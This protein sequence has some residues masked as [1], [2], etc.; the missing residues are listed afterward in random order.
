MASAAVLDV[1]FTESTYYNNA[2]GSQLCTDFEWAPDGSGR[3]FVTRK[4]S[5]STNI[6]EV[7]II[8]NGALSPTVF[9]SETV[10]T[11]GECGLLGLAFD[12]SFAT[13]SYVYFI[14]TVSATEQQIIRYTAVGNV[15]TARTVIMPGLPTAGLFH[16]GGGIGFGRDGK[17]Y[18]SIGES[19]GTSGVDPT[20]LDRDTTQLSA[21]VGRANR[22]G[23]ASPDN[24]FAD[25]AGPNN[26]YIWA[27]GLRN[28]FKLAFQPGTGA[29]WVSVAG[30]G[31]EQ[32]FNMARGDNAGW[33]DYEGQAPTTV[34]AGVV[35]TNPSPYAR[36]L[37]PAV[38]YSVNSV[39]FRL[40][41]DAQTAVVTGN[42]FDNVTV[43]G[44]VRSN[45]VSTITF[46]TGTGYS[47][48]HR[49][50][51][52]DKVF[53]TGVADA[54]FNGAFFVKSVGFLPV[55]TTQTSTTLTSF[56]SITFDQIGPNSVSGGASTG[57]ITRSGTTVTAVDPG[58][59]YLNTQQ[60]GGSVTGGTFFDSS[61]VPAAYRGNYFFGDYNSGRVNRVTM[62]A[63]NNVT[64][65]DFFATGL[66]GAIDMSIGPD[67][68]LYGLQHNGTIKRWAYIPV[69]Q[70]IVA[71]PFQLQVDEGSRVSMGVRLASAPA[72]NVTLTVAR[73]S[74][75]A[76]ISVFSGAN[77]TFTTANWA[78]PQTVNFQGSE[79]AD[80]ANDTAAFSLSAAGIATETVSVFKLDND[81]PQLLITPSALTI[82]EGQTSGLTIALSGPPSAPVTVSTART[83]GDTDLTVTSGSTL[84]FNSANYDVPQQVQLAAAQDPDTTNEAAVLTISAPGFISRTINVA[85]PDDDATPPEITT[86]AIT[87]AVIN[88][89]Y[90]Y[91]VDA[92]GSPAPTFSLTSHPPEMN[93]D[94]ISGVIA[95]TPAGL[96]SFNVT[97]RA[98]N[99]SLTPATQSFSIDVLADTP[100]EA[101]IT[102]PSD[103]QFVSG[104]NAEFYG[105]GHD[106]V[107]TVRG[108]FYIN[109][110]LVY[111][112]IAPGGH[113]HI[114]GTHNLWNTTLLANGRHTL[115]LTVVDTAGQTDSETRT[116]YVANDVTNYEAWK[117][118]NFTTT[119]LANASISGDAADADAD[120]YS[121]LLEYF[122]G[123]DPKQSDAPGPQ[124]G[125]DSGRMTLSFTRLA[126]AT[127][128]TFIVEGSNDL[129]VWSSA[130]I[131]LQSTTP[132]SG[133]R[134]RMV[135]RDSS[136]VPVRFGRVKVMR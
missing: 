96:G 12:P 82:G 37:R 70:G 126:G 50:C 75:D 39:D 15:G 25:G 107:Q 72:A 31:N 93:V 2:G 117:L 68:A 127:D 78:T 61:A 132:L 29:L 111:T 106:D 43:P 136:V 48:A 36:Y 58:V 4:G 62:G 54:S 1:N 71:T 16:N 35:A 123:S 90:S 125:L 8:Q 97:V 77:L 88:A 118:G 92:T 91:D 47:T 119:D 55:P 114:G 65:L 64:S 98:S 10:V 34:L 112:D 26:E 49:F 17:L 113:Y 128:T 9:A 23:T 94:P 21:K 57:I 115:R 33:N 108:E 41:A 109:D 11:S 116:I 79:D 129:T 101:H 45:N 3:I 19:Q 42:G 83:S 13:N 24:P 81:V 22:D 28:P 30:S 110:V 135:Y 105:D 120:G 102:Q 134:E 46:R 130:G 6:A 53:I 80:A 67:G 40:I 7:R 73:V 38:R 124:A 20:A 18:W 69:A 86:A 56:N 121:T 104:N 131:T 103:G 59:A 52:G 84:F 44:A 85:L 51:P 66:S 89:P 100:P 60:Y 5:S 99:A 133:G 27:G 63:T 122:F 74:G 32:I 76:D 87:S 95:W 14:L